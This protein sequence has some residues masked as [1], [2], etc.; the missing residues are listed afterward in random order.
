[1]KD[2]N[3]FTV[4]VL[5]EKLKLLNMPTSGHKSEL[6][7]RLS[8]A[9]PSGQWME[10][11]DPDTGADEFDEDEVGAVAADGEM[12]E[13]QRQRFERTTLYQKELEFAR[14]ENELMKREMEIMRRENELL[15]TTQSVPA[16]NTEATAR[17]LD[18]IT[19]KI[20]LSS[21]KEMLSDFDGRKGSYRRW[22]EQLLMVKRMYNLDDNF[23]KLLLGAKLTG[24]AADWF[25][26]V[27]AHL[28]LTV[29]ELL[30]KMRT[31]FDRREKRLSLR[32]EFENRMWLQGETFCEY[33]HKKLILANKV[34]I[35]E[36]EIVDYIIEGIPVKTIKYQAMMQHFP[37]KEAMLKAMEEI[38][39][40]PDQRIQRNMKQSFVKEGTKPVGQKKKIESDLEAKHEPKCFNCNMMG[41]IAVKCQM[42]KREKGAC[43]K[44]YQVGH[45]SKDCPTKELRADSSMDIGKK[46]NDVNSIFEE[47]ANFRRNISY[48]LC[49]DKGQS[50]VEN[51]LDTL[52]DT[53]SP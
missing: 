32:K 2:P 5:K 24:D 28:L 31:M 20:S 44:C 41:H 49:D 51:K 53:G 8:R 40:Y 17:R 6:I 26:S 16:A 36:E 50:K 18:S 15:R 22:K 7:L 3:T 1:M 29:D 34:P 19:P 33:F 23:T 30:N 9:D 14:H 25:H 4:T 47:D 21:V 38:S 12:I 13:E 35:D 45:K 39:L 37:N 43:F 27:S 46:K 11:I 48:Q 52:L 10:D 42:S